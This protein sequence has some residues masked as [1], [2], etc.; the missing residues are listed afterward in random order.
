MGFGE[1]TIFTSGL[2]DEEGDRKWVVMSECMD[3]GEDKEFGKK[4]LELWMEQIQIV[5]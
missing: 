1:Y 2:K 3:R 5:E 4:L